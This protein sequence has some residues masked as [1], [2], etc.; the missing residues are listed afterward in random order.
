MNNL[1]YGD[2][3]N[4]NAASK[5]PR[6]TAKRVLCEKLK[7]RNESTLVGADVLLR[8][9]SK[10]HYNDVQT[11]KYFSCSRIMAICRRQE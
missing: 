9:R 8:K 7:T 10:R 1:S 6:E 11:N 4:P 3:D 5:I 2:K